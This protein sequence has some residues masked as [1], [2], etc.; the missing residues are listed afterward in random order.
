MSAYAGPAD[1][2]TDSTNEGRMHVLT[3]GI[4][5]S[6]LLVHLDAG[7]TS[8]YSG[9]GTTWFD[10]SGN[11]NN[12]QIF[13]SPPHSSSDIGFFT[14]GAVDEYMEATLPE[15]TL[16]TFSY[17]AWVNATVLDYYQTILDF[18]ND[19]FYFGTLYSQLIT[20]DPNFDT[21]VN[22]NANQW[23]GLH[24]TH[25]DGGPF[26]F[27]VNGILVYTSTNNSTTKTNTILSIGGNSAGE[28]WN[29]KISRVALYN[30]SLAATEIQQSFN[31]LRGRFGI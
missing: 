24:L 25:T 11:G 16:S 13:G 20:F 18:A 8:S 14:M 3:K 17:E 27:Y 29:G 23:Y 30:K 6:N 1:W 9:T 5:Q 28:L 15:T 2:W 7:V 21:G 22:I 26:R 19:D 10:L 31:A 12:A 4:V